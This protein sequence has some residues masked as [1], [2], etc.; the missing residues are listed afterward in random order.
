MK[1]SKM[2]DEGKYW[3][4]VDRSVKSRNSK[5]N[6]RY[7]LIAEIEKLSP[8]EMV[9]FRL[10][11]DQLLYDTYTS[12]MW[13]AGEIM[14]GGC[15]D[16]A[17]EYFRC[18]VISRGKEVYNQAKETSDSLIDQVVGEDTNKYE[19]GDFMFE[20]F[21]YVAL[22]AFENRTGKNLYDYVDDENFKT[23]EGNYPQLE[24]T[25]KEEDPESMKKICPQLYMK[26][27]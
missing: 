18:W 15:S 27:N 8:E 10:R 6:Q 2:L 4:I 9:G 17:F 23:Q 24:F 19:F 11:T 25:W 26:F 12:D 3:E 20:E 13:C 1:T 7:F 16:D 22:E 14:N 21:W 5:I